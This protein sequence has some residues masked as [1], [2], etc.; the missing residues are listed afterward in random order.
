MKQVDWTKW[1]AVAEIFGAVAIVVSL[2]F[3]GFQVREANRETRAATI[4]AALDAEMVFQAEIARYAGT[5]EKVSTGA[6]LSEGEER[7]RGIV[8]FNMMMTLNENRFFQMRSGFLENQPEAVA[9][10]VTWPIY[11][12]W[13]TSGGYASRSPEYREFLELER[14]QRA[15]E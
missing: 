8:L 6:P 7:R 12:I 13:Q 11:E 9:L 10:G 4:Q 5:W 3:V 2:S 1:S 14:R 15:R